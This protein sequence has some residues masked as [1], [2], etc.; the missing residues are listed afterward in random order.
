MSNLA[1]GDDLFLDPVTGGVAGYSWTPGRGAVSQVRKFWTG[2]HTCKLEAV[3]DLVH[4][5]M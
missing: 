5:R 4:V 2:I 1:R 3:F